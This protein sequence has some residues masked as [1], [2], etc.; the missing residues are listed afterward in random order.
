MENASNIKSIPKTSRNKQ[1][2]TLLMT[3]LDL[4]FDALSKMISKNPHLVNSIDNK[5]ETLLSYAI[6]KKNDDVCQLILTSKTLDLSYQDKN[7]NTYLHLAVLYKLE[8]ISQILIEKGI[9][10]NKQ[11][12]NGKTCL[13]LAYLNNFESLIFILKNNKVNKTAKN[14]EKNL[15]EDLKNSKKNELMEPKS[16]G[17]NTKANSKKKD[18]SNNNSKLTANSTNKNNIKT[19]LK[20]KENNADAKNLKINLL[21]DYGK[22]NNS[23]NIKKI[24]SLPTLREMQKTQKNYKSNIKNPTSLYFIQKTDV[25]KKSK[26]KKLVKENINKRL[27]EENSISNKKINIENNT[28]TDTKFKSGTNKDK[29]S[30][31]NNIKEKEKFNDEQLVNLYKDDDDVFGLTD[32]GEFVKQ[33]AL[34][35]DL[36]N[37]LKEYPYLN[38]DQVK[39]FKEDDEINL[40]EEYEK[41]NRRYI[42][43]VINSSKM[44]NAKESD[45]NDSEIVSKIYE[46]DEYRVKFKNNKNSESSDDDNAGKNRSSLNI[47][48]N[49][50]INTVLNLNNKNNAHKKTRNN[51]NNNQIKIKSDTNKEDY[52][53]DF[54]DDKKFSKTIINKFKDKKEEKNSK[55]KFDDNNNEFENQ[56]DYQ[57]Y[58]DNEEK[59][60]HNLNELLN[61][62]DEKNNNDKIL[63]ETNKIKISEDLKEPL[64]L[65]EMEDMPENIEELED[66]V[67]NNSLKEFLAQ[68]NMQK[69][70]NNFI[71]NGFDDMKIII[72]QAQKG[73]YIKDSELKEAGILFP[74]DRAK[75]LIRIQEKAGNFRFAVPKSVYYTCKNLDKIKNDINIKNLKNWLKN[76]RIDTYLKNFISNG[77]HSLELLF[78]QMESQSPLTAEILKEEVGIDKIGHR[79]RI[80]NK[81]KEDGRSY[82]NKLKTS[83]LLVGNNNNTKFCDCII[84]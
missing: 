30:K 58:P 28:S 35:S 29:I 26:Y 75:I 67:K 60:N 31:T 66:I 59:Y 22:K 5:G 36:N 43:E 7:G 44:N 4:P 33:L 15:T 45:E 11:N 57:L 84:Y 50:I 25:G 8:K 41:M 72:A 19:N 71:E 17:R 48:D 9:N 61:I 52:L 70:L 27:T 21:F 78:L 2:K 40:K 76:L 62:N 1:T 47:L 32:S 20:V 3:H 23:N 16:K 13:D 79:S 18:R 38:I 53:Y 64:L 56:M 37:N 10:I 24:E 46:D 80:I 82:I 54:M 39:E 49:S 83:V 63:K 42:D 55:K 6:K 51:N 73:I 68:I 12:K 34:T 81:L 74:G 65:P 77:Y 14:K 69:Y